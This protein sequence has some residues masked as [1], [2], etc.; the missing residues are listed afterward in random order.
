MKRIYHPVKKK[1]IL[2][3]DDDHL[4][5]AIYQDKFVQEGF[6]LEVAADDDCAM[7]TF[8]KDVV[9][10]VVVDLCLPGI[11]AIELIKNIRSD[12]VLQLL[13]VVAFSNP[14]LSSLARAATEAGATR[15]AT[16]IDSTPEQILELARELGVTAISKGVVSDAAGALKRNPERFVATLVLNEPEILAKLRAGYL[17]FARAEQEDSRRAG[18]SEMHRQLRSL[19]GGA[20]LLGFEKI[21]QMSTALEALFIELHT[22]PAKISPSVVRTVAQ[23]IDTLASLFDRAANSPVEPHGM[24]P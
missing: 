15:C 2:I 9:D 23:A 19:T 18:L 22:K 21:A 12:S 10:L 13:P 11:N 8:K 17:D 5:L 24:R 3:V 1:T 4:A 14:Y 6:K 20:G 16:K 7:H